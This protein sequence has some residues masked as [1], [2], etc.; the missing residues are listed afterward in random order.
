MPIATDKAAG[1][2]LSSKIAFCFNETQRAYNPRN[3]P[4]QQRLTSTTKNFPAGFHRQMPVCLFPIF[5]DADK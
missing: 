1:I 2:H 3:L 4:H 5:G